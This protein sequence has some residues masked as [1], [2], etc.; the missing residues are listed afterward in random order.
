MLDLIIIG[1]GPAGLTAAIY[2]ARKKLDFKVL[3]QKIGGEQ[4]LITSVIENYPAI[5]SISGIEFIKKIREHIRDY[6]V[7]IEEGQEVVKVI[8][9]ENNFLVKTKVAK[10]Y[11]A[12][13]LIIASGRKPRHLGLPGEK[14]FEGRGVSFCSVCDAP[15]FRDRVVAVIGSGNAGLESALDLTKY[16]KKIYVLERASKVIGDKILQERLE[17]T[18]KVEFIIKAIAKEIKGEE[19]VSVL[20]YQDEEI[21]KIKELK[22][23]G[24][25]IHV[26]SATSVD[27]VKD[28]LELNV[29]GEIVIDPKSNQTSVEGI[30]AAGDVTDIKWKQIVVAAGEGAKAVLSVHEYLSRK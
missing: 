24:V 28:I 30:F 25:F 16:A 1:G 13:T 3:A 22:V 18:G 15:L 9:K 6:Q 11:T 17:E 27:F 23:T 8:K 29:A 26:G 19:F 2:A 10:E 21:Q 4:V 20:L 7:E 12:K 14:E 5:K